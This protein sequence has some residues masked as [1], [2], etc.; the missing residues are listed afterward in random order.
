L[1]AKFESLAGRINRRKSAVAVAKKMVALAWILMTRREFY[2]GCINIRLKE[3]T[4][5]LR[6]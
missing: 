1:Q 3:K 6:N 4:Y 2:R 5:S